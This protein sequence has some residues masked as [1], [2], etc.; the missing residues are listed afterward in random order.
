MISSRPSFCPLPVSPVDQFR[1]VIHPD[2]F[3]DYPRGIACNY[4]IGG[5]IFCHHRPGPYNN[6]V[7]NVYTGQDC[8]IYSN[9]APLSNICIN[10]KGLTVYP[11]AVVMAQDSNTR[12]NKAVRQYS[13]I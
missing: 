6:F 2:V 4:H 13:S 10:Q 8:R 9:E 5:N 11:L 3:A 1:P 7:T 12:S